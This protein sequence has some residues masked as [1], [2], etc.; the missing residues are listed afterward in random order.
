MGPG[1]GLER[2]SGHGRVNISEGRIN[3]SEGWSQPL[4]RRL[5]WAWRL[6]I[7]RQVEVGEQSLA[8]DA[9]PLSQAL[10]EPLPGLLIHREW[11]HA[12]LSL[13]LD[14]S[15]NEAEVVVGLA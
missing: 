15:D 2:S 11:L 4:L 14:L 9:V 13:T 12:L 1:E 6:L 7:V 3:V 8:L 5:A 10:L